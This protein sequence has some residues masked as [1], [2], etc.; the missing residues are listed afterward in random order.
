MAVLNAHSVQN[1]A[2]WELCTYADDVDH[3]LYICLVSEFSLGFIVL[4][5]FSDFLNSYKLLVY[6][7]SYICAEF[8]EDPTLSHGVVAP[9]GSRAA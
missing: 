8:Q 4:L 7:L 9:A 5:Y 2:S 6:I 3:I 1:Y